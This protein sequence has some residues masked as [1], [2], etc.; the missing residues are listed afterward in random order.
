MR[1]LITQ[2]RVFDK[3]KSSNYIYPMPST[4]VEDYIKRL[5]LAEQSLK[6][7]EL[8]GMGEIATS[9]G[10][11]PGTATS[12]V[13]TLVDAGLVRYEPRQGVRLT[14]GGKKLALYILRSHRLVELFLVEILGYDW[15]E[16]HEEAETLEHVVSEKFLAKI[17]ML[18][19][20]PETDPHG[21]PIPSLGGK[22]HTKN[23][24]RATEL[25]NEKS[26]TVSRVSKQEGAFLK[27]L[28]E[29]NII[30]GSTITC[31]EN[32]REKGTVTLRSEK[33]K[34]LV[35]SSTVAEHIFMDAP[36]VS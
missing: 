35:L 1:I 12:M 33:Q 9:M 25:L 8:V 2:N 36:P 14:N 30:P 5:Y 24:I 18:L 32:N 27:V 13:K 26:Y 17:D 19:G 23:C 29:Y 34:E 20:Q 10:V 11:Q 22:V 6:K 3:Q 16:V 7:D 15:S 4:T 21:D 28:S 31:V